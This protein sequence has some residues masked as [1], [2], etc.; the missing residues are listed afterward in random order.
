VDAASQE[1]PDARIARLLGEIDGLGDERVAA[2]ARALV[3]AVLEWH[4]RGLARAIEVAE[5]RG[6]QGRAWVAEL[7]RDPHVGSLLALHGLHPMPID[8]RARA[9][10]EDVAA[11]LRA[12]D[13]SAEIVEAGEQAVR[14]RVV[15]PPALVA[16]TKAIVDEAIRARLPDVEA[17]VVEAPEAQG[18]SLVPVERLR[19]RRTREHDACEGCGVAIDGAHEHLVDPSARALRC[20]CRACAVAA[21]APW[22]RVPPRAERLAAFDWSDE[23]WARLA[24]PIGLAFFQRVDGPSRVVALYPSPAGAVEAAI[25]PEAWDDVVRANPRLADLAPDVEA[26]LVRRLGHVRAYYRVSIDRA[27][28]LAGVIRRTWRGLAGGEEA[29]RAIAAYF[30]ELDRGGAHA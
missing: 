25:A 13:A 22:K 8:A 23:A 27:Y 20:A 29:S 15:A 30:D 1:S 12:L 10:V 11:D 17:V 28:A 5:A 21:A 2:S 3:G 9:A 14:A 18:E 24:I 26:L 6:A 16:R 4:G 7:A 19:A